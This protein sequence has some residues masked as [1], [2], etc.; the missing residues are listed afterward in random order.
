MVTRGFISILILLMIVSKTF[1]GQEKFIDV[2]QYNVIE[3]NLN[4]NEQQSAG[5]KKIVNAL[6]EKIDSI[7]NNKSL[8]KYS[9]K[10]LIKEVL[11]DTDSLILTLLSDKQKV[12]F[13]EVSNNRKQAFYKKV[14]K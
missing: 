5:Y 8:N 12:V 1:F 3:K 14:R 10:K 2:N 7:I 9:Q 11:F 4:L 13:V 6:Q